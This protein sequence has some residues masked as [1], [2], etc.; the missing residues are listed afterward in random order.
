[1]EEERKEREK[2]QK[3][4]E[5]LKKLNSELCNAILSKSNTEFKKQEW[6]LSY[7][8]SINKLTFNYHYN[9]YYDYGFKIKLFVILTNTL[10]F[11][12]YFRKCLEYYNSQVQVG[13]RKALMV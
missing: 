11:F 1:M 12:V 3:E 9:I 5:E 6:S 10:T 13:S 8:K 2:M 7:K 4:I